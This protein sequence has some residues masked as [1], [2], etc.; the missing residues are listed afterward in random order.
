[1]SGAV[2]FDL[3][4]VLID[5]EALQH[6][7][8][9]EVLRRFGVSIGI[10]EYAA[11]WTAAG[12]GPEYAVRTYHLAVE[13]RELRA[14]KGAVY[15]DILRRQVA[16][17]PGAVEALARLHARFPLGLAT[18][19]NRA[20][21][22]F[23][24]DHFEIRRFFANI[25]AREDYP[26]AKPEPD[27]YLASAAGLHVTVRDCL[28]VEDAYRGVLAAH[29]AGAR[30]LAVPNRFTRTNDFSL[31]LRVLASLDEL[32]VPVAQALLADGSSA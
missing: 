24:L 13:P 21:V 6:Q 5:S 23:V 3:D 32:T 4:G 31:A 1:M 11:H 22:A 29:R 26:L 2:I 17:M 7:A 9:A 10:D 12:R 20:D 14:L 15:H 28:V 27:A 16:L 18:N 8:Y 25:V 19:S 30:P